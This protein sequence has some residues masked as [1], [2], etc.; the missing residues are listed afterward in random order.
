MC[1]DI[2]S[3]KCCTTVIESICNNSLVDKYMN[4][5][6]QVKHSEE[7]TNQASVLMYCFSLIV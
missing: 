4:S 3:I 7:F 1:R 5:E 6:L 2:R